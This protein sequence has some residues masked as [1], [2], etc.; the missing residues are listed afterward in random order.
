[1]LRRLALLLPL[2]LLGC[3]LFR[4]PPP[5]PAPRPAYV[6]GPAYQAGGVWRYPR[7]DFQYDATG[8]AEALPEGTGL[9][10]DGEAFDG[11]A[12]AGAH[13]T[14]QLPV[15]ARVTNLQTGLQ[16][17]VRINDRGPANPARLLGLTARAADWLGLV[18][19]KPTRVRMQVDEVMSQALRDQLQANAADVD[20]APRGA[21][22]GA[23]SAEALTPPPGVGQSSRGQTVA[24]ARPDSGPVE[25][26]ATVPDRLPDQAMQV[27][28]DRGQLWIR[29][30]E[31]GRAAY[32]NQVQARLPGLPT[33][34][35]HV[36]QGRSE[37]FR[38]R[39]GPFA[40]V[41]A[42]DSALDQAMRAGVTDARIVVE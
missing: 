2:A 21:P 35:E 23:V 41:A 10:A 34:V 30:G 39:A 16:A 42:A 12:M 31:F 20:A 4:R 22:R 29:A 28:A 9:V 17:L 14:L 11:T 40:D 25:R 27:P 38:V 33:G 3:G 8:L 18:P 6:V 32:A 19:G 7:E 1:M 13:P 36:R 24:A 37:V 5:Q 26:A 15:I